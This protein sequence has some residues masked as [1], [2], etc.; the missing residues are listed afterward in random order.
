MSLDPTGPL[1][2]WWSSRWKAVLTAF[3]I[4]HPRSPQWGKQETKIELR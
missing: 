4:T 2:Q 1:A 3:D